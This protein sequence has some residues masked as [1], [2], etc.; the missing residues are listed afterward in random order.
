MDRINKRT[1]SLV[2]KWLLVNLSANK[3]KDVRAY[4]HQDHGPRLI[5][6]AG[7]TSATSALYAQS[8]LR[9]A[10]GPDVRVKS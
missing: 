5:K 10:A 6:Q 7:Y 4:S 8:L 1:N 2:T 3:T 9:N